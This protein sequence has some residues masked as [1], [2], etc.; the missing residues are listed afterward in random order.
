MRGY[1]E[2]NCSRTEAWGGFYH[3]NVAADT[4]FRVGAAIGYLMH[5]ALRAS[6]LLSG[7]ASTSLEPH[8]QH[9][10]NAPPC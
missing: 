4:R 2:G 9:L 7:Y 5:T 1:W 8:S 6:R 3:L 10:S